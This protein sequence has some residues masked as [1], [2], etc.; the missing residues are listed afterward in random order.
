M[1]RHHRHD[2]ADTGHLAPSSAIRLLLAVLA[3]A[4][5]AVGALGVA[6]PSQASSKPAPQWQAF[7]KP[8][9]GADDQP[10]EVRTSGGCPPPATNIIGRVYGAGFPKAG[11]NV[12]G[13][14]DAGVSQKGAFT[15]ALFKSMREFMFDQ[16]NPV[17]LRG[18]YRIVV[19]CRLPDRDRSYGDYVV[20]IRFT[21]PRA[22]VAARP[23]S[24]TPGYRPG[25][26]GSAPGDRPSGAAKPRGN[27]SSGPGAFSAPTPG[28]QA[29]P[30][31]ATDG[32]SPGA[33]PNGT[34]DQQA[35]AALGSTGSTSSR[36]PLGIGIA[37]V[38]GAVVLASI[39]LL[40]RRR[41]A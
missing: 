36:R 23:V 10:I 2:P 1:A 18:V 15:T 28:D 37:L 9:K 39:V 8:S 4:L 6:G 40:L 11:L 41:G 24:T 33:A 14:T 35:A 30:G 13:N 31:T 32:S 16:P 34:V 17:P 27:G 21:S 12:I 7:V 19:T 38:G 3:V 29:S 5:G 20:A 25:S 26:S 22:W